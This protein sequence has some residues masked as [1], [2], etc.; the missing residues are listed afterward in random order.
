M[1]GTLAER[2]SVILQMTGRVQRTMDV[3]PLIGT[4]GLWRKLAR[5]EEHRLRI[6]GV[7]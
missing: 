4:R 2:Y 5:R 6:R 7:V 1:K 3:W